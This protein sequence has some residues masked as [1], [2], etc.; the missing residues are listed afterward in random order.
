MGLL[1]PP[2]TT[3]EAEDARILLV[4]DVMEEIDW[5]KDWPASIVENTEEAV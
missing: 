1:L 3:T 4:D 2:S 5:E